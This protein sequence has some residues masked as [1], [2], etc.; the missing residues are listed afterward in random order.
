MGVNTVSPAA[1]SAKPPEAK[2][3]LP[4]LGQMLGFVRNPYQFTKQLADH[5]AAVQQSRQ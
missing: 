4:L 2:G 5:H 1:G 3:G